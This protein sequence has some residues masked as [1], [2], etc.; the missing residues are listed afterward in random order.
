MK[1]ASVVSSRPSLS[2]G[3]DRSGIPPPLPVAPRQG[4]RDL[5]AGFPRGPEGGLRFRGG[6]RSGL[7]DEHVDPSLGQAR[8]RA[9]RRV[10]RQGDEGK[11]EPVRCARSASRSV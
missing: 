8:D 10:V 7:V 4:D 5:D 3:D 6:P 11:V 2:L 9:G 1:T